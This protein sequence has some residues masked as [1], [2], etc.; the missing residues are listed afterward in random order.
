MMALQ[1]SHFLSDLCL[2]SYS[3]Q[4]ASKSLA[5]LYA[6]DGVESM[7]GKGWRD[8]EKEQQERDDAD[9]QK[10]V[11]AISSVPFRVPFSMLNNNRSRQQNKA[12]HVHVLRPPSPPPTPYNSS[13]AP[14]LPFPHKLTCGSLTILA[15]GSQHMI[16]DSGDATF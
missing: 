4:V 1:V 10:R 15:K 14:P 12:K 7:A 9:I 8:M 16:F 6:E 13:S 3:S 5:D 11:A 2:D